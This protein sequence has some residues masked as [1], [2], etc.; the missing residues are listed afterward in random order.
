M[1]TALSVFQKNIDAIK[2]D[3]LY[4]QERVLTVPQSGHISTT[5][6]AGVINMCAN[7]YLGLADNPVLI[8]RAKQALEQWGFGMASVRFI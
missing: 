5:V 3:G 1:K 2:E 6:K 8:E 7:N 4:K